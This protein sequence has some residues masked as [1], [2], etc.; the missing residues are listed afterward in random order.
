M[1]ISSRTAAKIAVFLLAALVLLSACRT[2]AYL[3]DFDGE[4]GYFR[5]SLISYLLY[6]APLLLAL[7]AAILVWLRSP[8]PPK[9]P[10]K[11]DRRAD[12][13]DE[14]S[15]CLQPTPSRARTPAGKGIDLGCAVAFLIAAAV[16]FFTM[17]QDLSAFYLLRVLTAVAAAVAFLLPLIRRA[18]L[19][20]AS[21]L[22]IATVA[23]CMLCVASDYFDWDTPMNSP[24]K[25][26][27]QLALCLCALY[28]NSAVRFA[29]SDTVLRRRNLFSA[30][31]AVFG[32]SYGLPGLLTVWKG[33][34]ATGTISS[35]LIALAL[36][37]HALHA[38]IPTFLGEV[39]RFILPAPAA[40]AD[41]DD[42][43]AKN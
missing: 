26:Y 17:G 25:I 8:A 40:L 1:K 35:F 34:Y 7:A 30:F 42:P 10:K 4:I 23:W 9:P 18:P 33:I 32:I 6:G 38:L 31:A 5:S 27:A 20:A 28:L 22:H 2:A 13:A 21:Y 12:D 16:D 43:S 24:V 41:S 3:T 11:A 39:P 29:F 19:P 14:P 36:G 15:P 37:I